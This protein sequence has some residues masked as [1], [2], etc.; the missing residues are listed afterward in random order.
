MS[1]SQAEPEVSAL[2]GFD[3]ARGDPLKLSVF[4][5]AIRDR[6]KARAALTDTQATVAALAARETW[7][8]AEE[9]MELS[10]DCANEIAD[11]DLEHWDAD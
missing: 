10:Y 8:D 3:P 5:C 4:I 7:E 11:T 9:E 6:F 1:D 2:T